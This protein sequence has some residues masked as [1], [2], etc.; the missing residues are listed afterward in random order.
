MHSFIEER[1]P[2][3]IAFGATGG[4]Q[5]NTQ[6][7]TL[8]S[9]REQRNQKWQAS[10]RRYDAGH[11]VRSV[12]ELHTILEFYEARR[13]PLVGFRFRDPLDHTSSKPGQLLTASDVK[14]GLGDGTTQTFKLAKRY[15]N[16]TGGYNRPIA[17]PVDGTVLLSING[18]TVPTA[19][20]TVD[21]ALGQVT[22]ANNFI[23]G[24]GDEIGAGFEFD[25]PVRFESDTLEIS[26]AAFEAGNIPSIPLIEVLL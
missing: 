14:I 21:T 10:R 17:K 15:G 12:A 2:V 25:V 16:D 4:P 19:N 13:G 7:I 1:F 6:I 8:G 3:S 26:L 24:E 11:G 23:P 9:G 22:F 18:T 20:Y 5:R